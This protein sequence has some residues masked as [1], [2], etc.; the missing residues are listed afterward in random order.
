MSSLVGRFAPSPTG[1]LHM[2]SLV[3][4]VASYLDI[5][6]RGGQWFVRIDNIDPPRE[7]PA[8]AADILDTLY[9]HGLRS[10]LPIDFQADHERRYEEALAALRSQ[11]FYCTCTRKMLARH[12][13]YPGTCRNQRDPV[14][15][16]ALRLRVSATTI[17]YRDTITG[18]HACDLAQD[19]GDFIVLRRDGLWSYTFATAI[20]DGHDCS[21]V[22]RGEDL[23]A[24]T[25]AQI[26]LMRLLGLQVPVYTHLP[27]LRYA[28]GAKLSKQTHAPALD[29][30]TPVQNLITALGYLHMTAP[31]H[32]CSTAADCLEWALEG[33]PSHRL[34]TALP[35]YVLT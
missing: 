30:N 8:A 26:Y 3:T 22:L 28:D 4:A 21:H 10:D 27:I 20:D 23:Q 14:P 24:T 32:T 7:S 11:L 12:N 34:P 13:T 1:P 16:A 25:P 33:W 35:Q 15:N 5:K 2:G 17:S 18:T 9:N 31:P 6:S 29:R 19:S